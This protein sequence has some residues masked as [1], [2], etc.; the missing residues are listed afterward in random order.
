MSNIYKVYVNIINKRLCSFIEQEKILTNTQAG[1]RENRNTWQKIVLLRNIIE[2]QKKREDKIHITYIDL[3]KAY[4]S[5]EHWGIEMTM[6]E[7]GF[8]GVEWDGR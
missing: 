4:D 8:D 3:A 7:M 5:V 2:L 1:F 6:R